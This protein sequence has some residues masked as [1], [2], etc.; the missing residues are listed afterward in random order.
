M[1]QRQ[2]TSFHGEPKLLNRL[3]DNDP[4][5]TDNVTVNNVVDYCVN[6]IRNATEQ[7]NIAIIPD[8]WSKGFICPIVKVILQMPKTIEML[9][10]AD[11]TVSFA[12]SAA[13]LQLALNAM[14]LYCEAWNLKVYTSKTNVVVFSKSRQ[15]EKVHFIYHNDRLSVIDEFQYLETNVN[16][17]ERSNDFGE[18]GHLLASASKDRTIR[19]WSIVKGRQLASM[20]L[21]KTGGPPG[22]SGRGKLWAAIVWSYSDPHNIVSSSFGGDL[23]LWDLAATGQQKWQPFSAT[24]KRQQHNRIIFNLRLGFT[25]NNLMATTSMDR[26]LIIWDVKKR[27]PVHCQPTLGGY[28]YCARTSPIDPGRIAL[29]VGDNMIRVW[30]LNNSNNPFD[31]VTLWQGIRSKVTALCWHPKKE[32]LLAYGTDDGR[33]GIYDTLANKPPSVS[34]NYHKRTVYVVSWGPQC[35]KTEGTSSAAYFLYSIGDGVVMQH[36]PYKLEDEAHD[37]NKLIEQSNGRKPRVPVRSE[38][39]WSPDFSVVA[40]GNDDG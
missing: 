36:D 32:G 12:K 34:S 30:N 14:Y 20:R 10:F 9:L 5:H 35:I 4:Q 11:D 26:Q 22:D 23:L 37:L 25:D 24:D 13:E 2:I 29:G 33:V 39:S 17:S 16:E 8:S 19:I 18:E 28:V 3:Q 27:R 38:I 15:A 1:G 21:P 7:A 31:V 40:I 6:I